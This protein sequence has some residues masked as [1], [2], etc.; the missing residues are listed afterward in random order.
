[1]NNIEELV[2]RA[3]IILWACDFNG[4][5]TL[6]IGG[7]LSNKKLPQNY[8]VGESIYNVLAGSE[9]FFEALKIGLEKKES[10]DALYKWDGNY[11]QTRI[12]PTENGVIGVCS[13]E[14]D[15][16]ILEKINTID[17]AVASTEKFKKDYLAIISHEI[18]TPLNGITGILNLIKNESRDDSSKKYIDVIQ[19][20]VDSLLIL[21]NDLLDFSKMESGKMDIE[22]KSFNLYNIINDITLIFYPNAIEKHIVINSNI[23]ILQ[24][25]KLYL[26]DPKRIT[27]ILNNIL[28]N[29]VKFTPE[30]GNINIE[31]NQYIDSMK[32]SI[33]D[34]GL[35]ISE[36]DVD[37]L[38]KPYSQIGF[39]TGTGLG[40]SISKSLIELMKGTIGYS[41]NPSTF[42]IKLPLQEYNLNLVTNSADTSPVLS[43]IIGPIPKIN[44]R[45]NIKVLI[46]EDDRTNNLVLCRYLHRLGFLDVVSKKNGRDVYKALEDSVKTKTEFDYVLLDNKMPFMTGIEVSKKFLPLKTKE[47]I[48]LVS[49][50]EQDVKNLGI[51]SVILK[52]YNIDEIEKQL[53]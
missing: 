29:A 37:K 25:D 5:I 20:S 46:A 32:I 34:S 14:N 42:W 10:V 38:F 8:A 17:F 30:Y 35:G 19:R 16:I 41:N 51:D 2:Q 43:P 4:I 22:S 11:C 49:G 1:M 31:I 26:G 33:I 40:L 3:S 9:G 48:I 18:R 53:K 28:S 15:K 50:E 44:L 52:P 27:Q 12:S 23:D 24:K 36:K 47:K 45:T 39:Q 13:I 21:V 6:Q 7:Q